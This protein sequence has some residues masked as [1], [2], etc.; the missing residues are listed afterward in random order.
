MRQREKS[1]GRAASTHDRDLAAIYIIEDEANLKKKALAA[2]P[3]AA[4]AGDW[5]CFDYFNSKFVLN[6]E[7]LHVSGRQKLHWYRCYPGNW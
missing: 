1:Y 2:F 7:A 4:I 6:K 3:K 5:I